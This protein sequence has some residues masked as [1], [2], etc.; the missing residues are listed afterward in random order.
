M[1]IARRPLKSRLE[2]RPTPNIST[3]KWQIAGLRDNGH[4]SC[5]FSINFGNST[6]YGT[7]GG[8]QITTS[9]GILEEGIHLKKS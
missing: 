4:Q 7:E 1:T 6:L 5:D 8:G 9:L 2:G 3:Y